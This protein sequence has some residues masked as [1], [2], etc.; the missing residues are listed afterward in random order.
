MSRIKTRPASKPAPDQN[1]SLIKTRETRLY[2]YN[3]MR[4]KYAKSKA[5]N[6]VVTAIKRGEFIHYS[7]IAKKYKYNYNMPFKRVYKL[8]KTR[9]DI[10]SFWY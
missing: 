10:N 7:N 6:K 2:H 8:I 4:D 9:K 1:P 5:I 3:K